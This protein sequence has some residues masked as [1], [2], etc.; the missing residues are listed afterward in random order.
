[1]KRF[2]HLGKLHTYMELLECSKSYTEH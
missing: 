1:M 2:F